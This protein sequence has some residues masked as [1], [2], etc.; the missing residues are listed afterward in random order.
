MRHLRHSLRR[1]VVIKMGQLL[2]LLCTACW[3]LTITSAQ[4]AAVKQADLNGH[5]YIAAFLNANALR[6]SYQYV[7]FANDGRAVTVPVA[8]VDAN[9]TPLVD[10]DASK[11]E[12]QAPARVKK[13]AANPQLVARQAK[14]TP[15]KLLRNNKASIS[16]NGV[17][18]K[19][20]GKLQQGASKQE[21]VV[22]YPAGAQR[23]TSV[24]LYRAPANYQY[25]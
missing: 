24:R 3:G 14:R 18:A 16:M 5:V 8:D 12:R 9:G 4:A 10:Q 25:H 15:V 11:A 19:P 17:Q 2:L 21:F 7:F 20:S 23:Y 1:N 13:L 22:A 6:T